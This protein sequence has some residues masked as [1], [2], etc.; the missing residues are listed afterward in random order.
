MTDPPMTLKEAAAKYKIGVATL[1]AEA[2]RGRLT[3]YRIGRQDYTTATDMGEMVEKCRVDQKGRGF[4][5][6]KAEDLSFAT[7]RA[8]SAAGQTVAMLKRPSR[9]I[10]DTSTSRR[11]RARQ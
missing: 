11:T 8:L 10:S 6:K 4:T 1:R 7:A 5:F 2:A 3:I 9:N